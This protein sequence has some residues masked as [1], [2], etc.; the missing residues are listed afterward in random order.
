MREEI[1]PPSRVFDRPK[2]TF[3]FLGGSIEQGL[4]EDW[5]TKLINSFGM[6]SIT[7]INPRRDEWDASWEQ[8]INSPNFYEQV[9]WEL[10]MLD[11]A[12]IIVMNFDPTTKSPISLLEL[13]LY[14]SSGKLVVCC[15][16][17]FWRKGNVDIVCQRYNIPVF[18]N[19]ETLVIALK[20]KI[21]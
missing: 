14:A 7:F 12:D 10:D 16:D 3:V 21:N 11:K 6:C 15:P 9:S 20:N 2:N 8:T 4:A 1:K 5:Q 18:T 17:G 13:G 19:L